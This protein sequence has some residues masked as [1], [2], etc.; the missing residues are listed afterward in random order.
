[1]AAHMMDRVIDFLWKFPVTKGGYV[2]LMSIAGV[3]YHRI[4]A[5]FDDPAKA[6]R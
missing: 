5:F 1:M 4:M 2:A 3:P 6:M